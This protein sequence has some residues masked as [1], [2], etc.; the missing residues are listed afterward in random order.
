M[1]GL[2]VDIA[3]VNISLMKKIRILAFTLIAAISILALFMPPDTAVSILYIIPLAI[4]F[5]EDKKTILIVA[6]TCCLLMIIDDIISFNSQL[7]Y[8]IF[9]NSFLAFLAI[10]LSS[11]AIVKYK[12]LKEKS[13]KKKAENI[14]NTI[15]MLFITSHKFRQPICSIQGLSDLLEIAEPSSTELKNIFSYLKDSISK[16]DVYSKELTDFLNKMQIQEEM[17]SF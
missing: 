13:E 10:A 1:F 7:E 2:I 16:L 14:K 15:E 5:K 4:I 8:S 12:I 6:I 3:V 9:I 17:D 11:L